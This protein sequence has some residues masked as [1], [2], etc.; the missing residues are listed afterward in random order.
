MADNLTIEQRR[1][2]MS[3]IR[4]RDTKVE[5]LVRRALHAKGFR[6]R[7]NVSALPGKPDIAFTRL[8]L[9]VFVDGDFWHGWQFDEWRE[10]LAPY[11]AEKIARNIQRD[12]AH[13]QRLAEEGW[14]VVRI[15]EHEVEADL[16]A[17]IARIEKT[18]DSLR[19]SQD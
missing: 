3:R 2:T 1:L 13:A 19:N 8:R 4:S 18:I 15:W 6:Y 17:C 7:V 10:K 5:L 16:P 14:A 11:W 12:A 9:A